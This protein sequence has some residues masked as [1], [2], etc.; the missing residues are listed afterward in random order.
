MKFSIVKPGN[1][2]FKDQYFPAPQ[3]SDGKPVDTRRTIGYAGG[4]GIETDTRY[5][6]TFWAKGEGSISNFVWEAAASLPMSEK[7]EAVKTPIQGQIVSLGG[8]WTRVSQTVEFASQTADKNLKCG[9]SIN[10]VWQGDGTLYLDDF[11]LK[12]AE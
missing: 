11:S 12:K 8:S 1:K 4:I 6:L 2:Y 9:M 3:R 5:T 7:Q 10:L